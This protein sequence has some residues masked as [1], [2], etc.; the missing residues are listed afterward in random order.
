MCAEHPVTKRRVIHSKPGDVE[1][2]R[3][4]RNNDENVVAAIDDCVDS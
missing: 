3:N 4:P 1:S 2:L